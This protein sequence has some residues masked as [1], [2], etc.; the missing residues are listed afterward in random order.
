[1]SGSNL[2]SVVSLAVIDAAPEPPAAEPVVASAASSTPLEVERVAKARMLAR[3]RLGNA[4]ARVT[5]QELAALE[6]EEARLQHELEEA[7][8]SPRCLRITSHSDPLQYDATERA[9]QGDAAVVAARRVAP[10]GRNTADAVAGSAGDGENRSLPT[11]NKEAVGWACSINRWPAERVRSAFPC[12][13][14][15]GRRATCCYLSGRVGR[16][17]SSRALWRFRIGSL[18]T[19]IKVQRPENP[20]SSR[21]RCQ[22]SLSATHDSVRPIY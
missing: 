10:G 22:L 2:S 1:M 3:K 14:I 17:V 11:T 8:R 13:V 4:P 18:D 16:L 7:K 9:A 21:L 19:V 20:T 5:A 15:S 12:P 6:A